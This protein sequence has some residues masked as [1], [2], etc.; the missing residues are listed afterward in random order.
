M[1][2]EMT[3]AHGA[4]GTIDPVSNF[5]CAAMPGSNRGL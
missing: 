2:E 5:C 1:K 4:D 3:L